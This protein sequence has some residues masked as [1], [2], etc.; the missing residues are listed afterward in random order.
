LGCLSGGGWSVGFDDEVV[1]VG[2]DVDDDDDGAV[3]VESVGQAPGSRLLITLRPESSCAIALCVGPLRRAS[4]ERSY[5]MGVTMIRSFRWMI[6]IRCAAVGLAIL[7]AV[8]LSSCSTAP[9]GLAAGGG[10][11]SAPA[12]TSSLS[13]DQTAKID[14]MVREYLAHGIT[15]AIVSVSDPTRGSYLKAYGTSDTAGTPMTTDMHYRIASVSKTFTADA[16]LRLADQQK[17]SLDDPIGKYVPDI[18]NGDLITV[19]NLLAMRG[20]VY[21]FIHDAGFIARDTADP[22]LP[23]WTPEDVLRIIRA[24]PGD[25]SAPDQ[26][27]VYSNSEYVLLGFVIEKVTGQTAQQYLTSLIGVLGLPNT[28]FPTT[29]ALPEPFSRGYLI[30]DGSPKPTIGTPSTTPAAALRDATLSNPLVPWTSGALI[31]TVPDMTRYAPELATGA[32]LAPDT[33][34]LR[35]TWTSLSSTGGRVQYGLG[36]SRIGDWVGHDGRISGYS[37]MV[38]YLPAQRATVV[39]M[40]NATDSNVTKLWG[41]IV[42]QLYPDSLPNW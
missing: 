3:A 21:N 8:G 35:Q 25:A 24:H 14:A 40:V 17:L 5:D 26:K 37:D 12:S 11:S 10:I 38:F 36:V 29:D 20:G 33:A 4:P 6:G 18:P 39:V 15:G 30:S 28:F 7:G 16:V 19:R 31:S 1:A 41:D 34:R 9:V 2:V 23:G 32:G 22:T 42:E 27:T 13:P